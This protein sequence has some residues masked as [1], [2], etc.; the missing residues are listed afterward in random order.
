MRA[1]PTVN[2]TILQRVASGETAAVQECIAR[3]GGLIGALARRLLPRSSEAEDAVQEVFIDLWRNAPRYDA[4]LCAE[5]SFVAMFAR[6]R[7]IDA[8]RRRERRVQPEAL[9]DD[10]PEAGD[11]HVERAEVCDDAAVARR[12]FDELRPEEQRVLRLSI[13]D[14]LSHQEIAARTGLPLGTV[15]THARRGLARVRELLARRREEVRR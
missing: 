10:P 13:Y 12:A 15:K 2:A 3:Y 5:P 9:P 4:T 7:L 6:R 11:T 14:G 1:P 8:R